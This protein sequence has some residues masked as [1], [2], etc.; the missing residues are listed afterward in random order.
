MFYGPQTDDIGML[1]PLVA[2]V[3][4]WPGQEA[5]VSEEKVPSALLYE[6]AGDVKVMSSRDSDFAAILRAPKLV[7]CGASATSH[8]A[9]TDTSDP[10]YKLVEQ[11][12]THL[13]PEQH[14]KNS[15]LPLHCTYIIIRRAFRLH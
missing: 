15:H 10:S 8:Y 2:C 14:L 13:F 12:K 4:R 1:E 7:A 5:S 3:A 9:L 6:G 11:F